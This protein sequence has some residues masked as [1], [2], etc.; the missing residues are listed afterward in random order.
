MVTMN[1]GNVYDEIISRSLR[2]VV[3][4]GSVVE[5]KRPIA[6]FVRYINLKQ[7]LKKMFYLYTDLREAKFDNKEDASNFINECLAIVSDLNYEDISQYTKLLQ[8]KFGDTSYKFN[9]KYSQLNEAINTLVKSVTKYDRYSAIGK[10]K[11]HSI[12]LKHLMTPKQELTELQVT[13][14]PNTGLM[15]LGVVINRA[16]DKFNTEYSTLSE[17]EQKAFKLLT[18]SNESVLRVEFAKLRRTVNETIQSN[19]SELPGDIR[20]KL[21]DAMN[22]LTIAKDSTHSEVRNRYMSLVE[23]Y[24]NLNRSLSNEEK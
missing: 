23:L 22:R 11:A 1:F 2:S 16:I 7:P 13:E 8:S 6:D 9:S 17:M 15:G 18:H 10:T 21:D 3:N 12:V 4:G 14:T 20:L 24:E 5:S 19:V